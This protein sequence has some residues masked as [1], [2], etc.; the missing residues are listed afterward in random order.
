MMLYIKRVF[1]LYFI[2]NMMKLIFI[3][4]VEKDIILFIE[5]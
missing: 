2:Y 4:I 5:R 3:N 1:H